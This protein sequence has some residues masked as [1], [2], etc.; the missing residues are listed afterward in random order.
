MEVRIGV[1]N[2]TREI[3][4]ESGASVDEITSTIDT[5]LTNKDMLR[6]TDDKGR[7]Y[8]VPVS[9]LGYVHIG[10]PEKSRVGFGTS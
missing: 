7:L 1:Q 6:L 4:F 10:E 3:V 9:A 8:I 2:V 5:A